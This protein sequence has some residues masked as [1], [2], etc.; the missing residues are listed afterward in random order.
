[1]VTTGGINHRAIIS[2][3]LRS[4]GI[5]TQHRLVTGVEGKRIGAIIIDQAIPTA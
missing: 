2:R 4:S 5:F 1:V 3:H